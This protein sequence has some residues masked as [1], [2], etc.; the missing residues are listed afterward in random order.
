MQQ[1]FRGLGPLV[2]AG[3]LILGGCAAPDSSTQLELQASRSERLASQRLGDAG[4]VGKVRASQTSAEEW[5]TLTLAGRYNDP[6]VIMQ[7]PAYNGRQPTTVRVRNVR[8]RS[9][10]FQSDEWDYL[11]GAHLTETLSYLVVDQGTQNLDG[12]RVTAGRLSVGQ[13]EQRVALDGF[14]DTPVVLSQLQTQ[15]RGGAA[16]TRQREV[17]AASFRVKMQREEAAERTSGTEMVGYV[18]VEQGQGGRLEAATAPKVSD[19]WATLG[20][21]PTCAAPALLAAMQTTNGND[22][23]A[24]RLRNLSP[25]SAQIKVEEE[26]SKGAETDHTAEVVGFLT[27]DLRAA[28][29]GASCNEEAKGEEGSA[30]KGG[31][32][33]QDRVIVPELAKPAPLERYSDPAFGSAVTRISSASA[34]G[35]VKPM[36]NT[37]QAWNADESRL[38]LYHAGT[39]KRGHHLYDGRRYSYIKPLDIAPSDIEEVYWDSADS[40]YFYY[41]SKSTQVSYGDLIRYDVTNDQQ[42][43]LRDFSDICGSEVYPGGGNDVQMMSLNADLIGLRCNLASSAEPG[44]KTFYYRLSTDSVGPVKAIGTGTPYQPWYAAQSAPSAER[45]FLGG[46]VLSLDM[47]PQRSLDVNRYSNGKYRPEHAVLGRL[48]NGHDALY[49]VAFNVSP[50]G[51]DG[52][53]AQGVGS[54]VAH[55]L[56]TGT[57]RVLIGEDNGYGYPLSGVHPSALSYR[58]PGWIAVSSVGNGQLEYLSNGEVAPL[59]FSEIYLVNSD[60]AAPQVYRLAHT[61]TFGKSAQ[62]GGYNGYFGEPHPV[63]S[64]SGTRILFGSDW[65]DSGSVDTYV[66]ELPTYRP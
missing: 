4:E 56:E 58:D 19:A 27:L 30:Q 36:Y 57:C 39:Q 16:L 38:I 33:H 29:S 42:R 14:S 65:Y 59:L 17:S 7:P 34:G 13:N 53:D 48:W 20:F 44:D 31:V 3:F 61:R 22:S 32:T 12:L 1:P 15:T 11:D 63:L 55:D 18:A 8:A 46:D 49:A 60:P 40:R 24:L 6:I 23:A 2:L 26:T 62:N 37:V 45:V 43:V 47:K 28:D 51:C 66:I 50:G 5:H 41:V 10:E 25:N 52:G 54:L 9:F 35:V 64:P 21:A